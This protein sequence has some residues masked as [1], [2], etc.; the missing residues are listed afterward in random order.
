MNCPICNGLEY[1]LLFR[2]VNRRENINC[3]GTYVECNECSLVYLNDVPSWEDI[4]KLY[5]YLDQNQKGSATELREQTEKSSVPGWKKILRK[6]RFRPHSWPL[7]LAQQSGNSLLDLG[8]SNTAKLT[9]FAQ[10]GYDVW[11]VDL[12]TKAI[13]DSRKL[14]PQGHFFEGEL[15]K[16]DLPRD[17]FHYIRIDNV[18][19]HVPNPRE[20]T[21]ECYRL[22]ATGGQILIYVPHGKSLSMQLMKG[23]SISSWIP[24]HLQ[25]F[26][27][28]SLTLLLKDAGFKSI[29]IYNYYPNSWLPLS[30]LQLLNK[31]Q[32]SMDLECPTWLKVVCYPIGWL[33]AI[34]GF[35]EELVAI[36][37]K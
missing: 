28:K 5:S 26:T 36:G 8:C 37:S 4:V 27:R 10:R 19:E 35:G 7:E 34:L 29:I 33:T 12:S 1:K 24:F 30:I 11:G 16:V 15:T 2:D 22:L 20:I 18:L 32:Q 25:L 17:Y 14:L 3:S 31:K 21:K 13:E 6:I 9:E 23:S